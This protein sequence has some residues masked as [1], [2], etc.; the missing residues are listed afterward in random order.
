MVSRVIWNN[1]LPTLN[2]DITPRGDD[3]DDDDDNHL[4]Q[5]GVSKSGGGKGAPS[6]TLPNYPPTI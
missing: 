5:I 4:G 6:L 1:Q 3:D 2:N